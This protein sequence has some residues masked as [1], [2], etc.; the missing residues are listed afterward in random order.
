MLKKLIIEN[1][2]NKDLLSRMNIVGEI[3]RQDISGN[4]PEG[5]EFC[6]LTLNSD[7]LNPDR[8]E[9]NGN[10]IQMFYK[11]VKGKTN[12]GKPYEAL[13]YLAFGG[14][15][16][17]SAWNQQDYLRKLEEVNFVKIV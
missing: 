10:G 12:T 16:H 5:A 14:S 15:W 17:G 1:T 13:A 2:T 9:K 7:M 11:I 8:E 4:V 3:R 6:I